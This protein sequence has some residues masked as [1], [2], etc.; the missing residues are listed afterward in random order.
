MKVI[1]KGEETDLSPKIFTAYCMGLLDEGMR[2][3]ESYIDDYLDETYNRN[4]FLSRWI[5]SMKGM[6]LDKMELSM[7]RG[8]YHHLFADKKSGIYFHC[9]LYFIWSSG[10]YPGERED[11]AAPLD[12][13]NKWILECLKEHILY[14]GDNIPSCLL[15]IYVDLAVYCKSI[16]QHSDMHLI[17]AS[18]V[19]RDSIEKTLS[20]IDQQGLVI[21]DDDKY[22]WVDS[23]V[24]ARLSN[25]PYGQLLL[26]CATKTC[27]SL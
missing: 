8:K 20:L 15:R 21:K 17:V 2:P 24:K 16:I 25:Y 12:M 26:D 23:G 11:V 6:D 14:S 4:L 13:R 27:Q 5:R 1:I 10:R 9:F 22:I 19:N 7:N 3:F 18:Y